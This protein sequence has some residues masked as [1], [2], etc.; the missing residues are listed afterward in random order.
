MIILIDLDG[1]LTDT[2]DEKFKDFKD[3]ILETKLNEIPLIK[4]AKEFINKLK[5]DKH[6]P[7]I[8]SDSHPKYVSKISKE[9]FDVDFICLAD[10]PN[11]SKTKEHFKSIRASVGSEFPDIEKE[12]DN[13]IVIGDTFLDIELGRIL[14]LPTI[15]TNFYT[16]KTE[17]TR[18]GIGQDWKHLKS[19]ATYYANT[20]EDIHDILKNPLPNLLAVEAIFQNF[21]SAKAVRFK[22]K[23][24]ID[25]FIAY[26]TLGRQNAGECDRYA[27]AEKYF[28]FQRVDRSSNSLQLLAR[29]TENY[30]SHVMKSM[31]TLIWHYL[32][33]VSDKSTTIPPNKMKQLF[34]LI[35]TPIEKKYLILWKENMEGSIK[36]QKDYQHR[37]DFVKDNISISNDTPLEGKN[38][39]IIDDQFTTGGTAYSICKKFQDKGVKNM[40][41]VTLFYL[42]TTVESEK[43]CI[44]CGRK[45]EIKINR[46]RGDRFYSCTPPKYN[47]KGCGHTEKI[48]L[49]NEG[50]Q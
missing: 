9:I 22:T 45:M 16:S 4:G 40:I 44:K 30:F 36:E 33:Y 14:N 21:N 10:K 26:R 34:E 11:P 24:E 49:A 13:F 7:F 37:R 43:V 39:I 47:G 48:K 38:I 17:Q 5:H 32:T 1:T 50:L 25:S 3:G 6:S 29:A 28:E 46:T 2:S 18:D 15:L 35:Q 8:V 27:V 23:K 19:G 41:F 12:F 20:F 31:P 42:I